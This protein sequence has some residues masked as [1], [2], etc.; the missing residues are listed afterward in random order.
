MSLQNRRSLAVEAIYR[1][2]SQIV[3]RASYSKEIIILTSRG[4][5]KAVLIGM[6]T[7]QEIFG[8]QQAPALSLTPINDFRR[9]FL[10]ALTESGYDSKEK[11]INM[12]REVKREVYENAKNRHHEDHSCAT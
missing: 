11:I 7:F 1:Q 10:Q 4:R 8:E 3:N 9:Q 5:P 2:L 6:D 12:I